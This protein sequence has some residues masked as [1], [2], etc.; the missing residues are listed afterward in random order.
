MLLIQQLGS[1]RSGIQAGGL[2]VGHQIEGTCRILAGDA[3][4]LID[5][6]HQQSLSV[7]IQGLHVL[8]ALLAGG[9]RCHAAPLNCG[10]Y[11]G[12]HVLQQ[13]DH[14]GDHVLGAGGITQS[15][16]GHRVGLGETVDDDGSFLHAGEGSDGYEGLAGPVQL[17]VH[18]VGDAED[19]V[20]DA[21]LGQSL[22][23]VVVRNAAGGVG[24]EVDQHQLGL[25]GDGCS[26]RF[27]IEHEA[28]FFEDLYPYG[29]AAQHDDHAVVCCVAGVGDDDF[30][31][32]IQGRFQG[33]Q[34]SGGA[35]DGDDHFVQ[36]VGQA[37]FGVGL[38]DGFSQGENTGVGRIEGFA[39]VQ[40]FLH[41]VGDVLRRN[42]VG[43]AETEGQHVVVLVAHANEFTDDRSGSVG[44]LFRHEISHIASLYKPWGGYDRL[45]IPRCRR[46]SSPAFSWLPYC[47]DERS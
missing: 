16:T 27:G 29:L 35:A 9:E 37:S 36:T 30:I 10:E 6:F 31:A 1:E 2:D 25:R 38:G 18:F 5:A 39:S 24:G 47:P 26:D 34:Q 11:G 45:T 7:A 19:V 32:D 12:E 14:L 40:R 4:D 33:Q 41:R 3:V 8:H 22:Q 42:E 20:L 17:S 23:I 46:S 44:T 43:L 15:C 21:D 13:H 28:V